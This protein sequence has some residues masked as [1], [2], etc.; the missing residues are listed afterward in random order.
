MH[1]RLGVVGNVR[2]EDNIWHPQQLIPQRIL[3]AAVLGEIQQVLGF[4]FIGVNPDTG[5]L[6]RLKIAEHGLRVNQ[7]WPSRVDHNR[8]RFHQIKCRFIDNVGILFN[9]RNMKINDITLLKEVFK[10][11][12]VKI[13]VIALHWIRIVS[14]HFGAKAFEQFDSN[15][16]NM[17]GAHHAN[18]LLDRVPYR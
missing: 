9:P 6:A 16:S 13:W 1:S 4:V 10:A 15:L 17:T 7:I 11:D 2:A 8:T 5:Q 3:E 12:I 14:N 18:G